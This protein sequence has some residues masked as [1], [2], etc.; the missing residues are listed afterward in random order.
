MLGIFPNRNLS[1]PGEVLFFL[2]WGLSDAHGS[3]PGCSAIRVP[4]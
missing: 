3:Q 4:A 2:A 1:E